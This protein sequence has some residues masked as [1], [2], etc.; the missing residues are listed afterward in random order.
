MLNNLKHYCLTFC[1]LHVSDLKKKNKLATRFC[2][3]K[4]VSLLYYFE[5]MIHII[6]FI[7]CYESKLIISII[8]FVLMSNKR[9]CNLKDAYSQVFT[10]LE[11]QE[12]NV[13]GAILFVQ[14]SKSFNE[15]LKVAYLLPYFLKI[16]P[17]PK[18]K[19]YINE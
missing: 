18:K 1:T 5:I 6:K 2:C 11:I 7:Q 10:F 12:Q 16:I 19:K 4:R 13:L 14:V 9:F 3:M 8:S 17:F 15:T